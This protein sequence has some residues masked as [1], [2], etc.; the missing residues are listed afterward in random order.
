MR[1]IR[2]R[3]LFEGRHPSTPAEQLVHERE[4][5]PVGHRVERQRGRSGA[6]VELVERDE[7]PVSGAD[8]DALRCVRVARGELSVSLGP[9][10]AEPDVVGV[11]IEDDQTE[12]GLDEEPLQHEA[13][14]VGLSGARLATE[15]CVAVEPARIE[16]RWHA[17]RQQELTDR[18]RR[19]RRANRREPGRDVRGIRRAC[20]CIVKRPPVAFEDN[21]LASNGP[22]C[23]PGAQLD[24]FV[25]ARHLRT[26]DACQLERYHLA[27]PSTVVAL[28]HDVAADLQLQPVQRSLELEAPS[29]HRRRERQD[30]LLDLAPQRSEL[31]CL[32][33]EAR[34]HVRRSRVT[35]RMPTWLMPVSIICGRRAAGR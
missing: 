5:L 2:R 24:A 10:L 27:E 31:G 12:V 15:E 32:A 8:D 19:P 21:S 1:R 22:K 34:A 17:R 9:L 28:E 29:V 23:H 11:G 18:Q 4:L 20:Q 26:V 7:E 33:I 3:Q 14:R 35:Q 25:A 30:R 13:E 6:R 16:R